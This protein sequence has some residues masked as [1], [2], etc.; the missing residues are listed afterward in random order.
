MISCSGCNRKLIFKYSGISFCP[1]LVC[2]VTKR[3]SSK[4]NSD[5]SSVNTNYC[6]MTG[7]STLQTLSE[8][9]IRISTKRSD[10]LVIIIPRQ[11]NAV[12]IRSLVGKFPYFKCPKLNARAWRGIGHADND[13]YCQVIKRTTSE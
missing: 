8:V 12:Y 10:F 11:C 6:I 13:L 5:F 1:L 7:K 3:L 9:R 2:R 4:Q